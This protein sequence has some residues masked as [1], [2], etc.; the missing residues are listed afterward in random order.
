MPKKQRGRPK[1]ST[2]PF[3][4]DR[5]RFT[6][7]AWWGFRGAGAGPYTAAYWASIATSEEP[8]RPEDV[9]SLLTVAG[10]KIPHTAVTLD[11]HL[12]HLT[13]KAARIPPESDGW[14]HVSAVTIKALVLAARTGKL[15][16]YCQMLD[17]LLA[18]GWGDVIGRLS[19]RVVQAS[20]SNVP[21]FEGELGAKGRAFLAR[22]RAAKKPQ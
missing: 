6:I 15:E 4:R 3:Q 13:R 9:E 19:E 11:K 16:I 5:Q 1:G 14:L 21:P 22:L 7:A 8:I 18:I 2:V 10:T 17:L 20:K 12:D